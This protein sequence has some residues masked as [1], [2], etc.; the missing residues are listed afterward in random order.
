[1]IPLRIRTSQVFSAVVYNPR[2]A[3]VQQTEKSR[4]VILSNTNVCSWFTNHVT[5]H[6]LGPKLLM[7]VATCRAII[8]D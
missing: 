3:T 1:M 8:S 7:E 6:A 5:Q 4:P 2:L